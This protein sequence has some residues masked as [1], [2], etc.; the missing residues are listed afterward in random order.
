MKKYRL[1]ESSTLGSVVIDDHNQKTISL[2]DQLT[3]SDTMVLHTAKENL[4]QWIDSQ[5]EAK[6]ASLMDMEYPLLNEHLSM[7]KEYLTLINSLIERLSIRE[8]KEQEVK[9]I[10]KDH[11]L[12]Y[13]CKADLK[14]KNYQKGQ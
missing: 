1:I 11:F 14:Q 6:E 8:I 7:H 9:R 10:L 13:V 2:I 5:F 4:L 3:G 12:E